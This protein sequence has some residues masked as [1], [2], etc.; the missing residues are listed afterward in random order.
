MAAA[1]RA[2][3]GT[4]DF[5]AFSAVRTKKSTV[6]TLS[7]VSIERVRD[8]LRFDYTADGFLHRMVRILTGTLL[9]VGRGD[10]SPEAVKEILEGRLRDEAGFTVPA[11]GLCLMEV[12][13]E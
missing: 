10:R 2:F 9:E 13:Y 5:R 4:H 12:R 11:K 1:G 6:R 8:E 7:R 3:E